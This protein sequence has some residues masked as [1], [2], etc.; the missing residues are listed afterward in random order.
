MKAI[1]MRDCE[2]KLKEESK[3]NGV[4]GKNMGIICEQVRRELEY[5]MDW[6]DEEGI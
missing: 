1:R 4:L 2:E 3:I 6:Y 5:R